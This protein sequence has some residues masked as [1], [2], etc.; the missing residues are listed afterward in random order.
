[1]TDTRAALKKVKARIFVHLIRPL[2][3]EG[4]IRTCPMC[5]ELLQWYDSHGWLH[6]ADGDADCWGALGYGKGPR[7][8]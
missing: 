6:L 4:D 1:M 7:R 2:L 8:E 3:S 5:G